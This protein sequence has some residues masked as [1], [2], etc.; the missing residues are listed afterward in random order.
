MMS[1]YG[2]LLSEEKWKMI[3]SALEASAIRV[4]KQ[5]EQESWGSCYSYPPKAWALVKEIKKQLAIAKEE[6]HASS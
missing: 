3:I 1:R 6:N 4:S 5:G 2:I